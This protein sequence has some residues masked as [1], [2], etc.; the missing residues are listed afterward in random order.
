MSDKQK[1]ASYAASYDAGDGVKLKVPYS[2]FGSSF[3]D[4]ELEPMPRMLA[5]FDWAECK[6]FFVREARAIVLP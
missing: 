4:A 3:D 6:A 2:F 1:Q 5:P